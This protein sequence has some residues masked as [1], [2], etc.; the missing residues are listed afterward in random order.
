MLCPHVDTAT[1]TNIKQAQRVL[2]EESQEDVGFLQVVPAAE[3]YPVIPAGSAGF[4]RQKR[5]ASRVSIPAV[6]VASP[7]GPQP[8]QREKCGRQARRRHLHFSSTR[9]PGGERE[10]KPPGLQGI[11]I[12]VSFR[13]RRAMA[14]LLSTACAVV[15]HQR[16]RRARR[17]SGTAAWREARAAVPVLLL[18]QRARHGT[19]EL[20]QRCEQHAVRSAQKAPSRD[21]S[22]TPL[23]R[24]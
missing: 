16:Y 23:R 11:C 12:C 4:C 22:S 13:R 5:L 21:A 18:P 1:I 17:F 10:P 9:V 24:L 15:P 7:A 3:I 6:T 20:A 8:P 2:R 14:R 19:H